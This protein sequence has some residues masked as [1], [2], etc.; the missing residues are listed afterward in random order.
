MRVSVVVAARHARVWE[1]LWE[2]VAQ[3]V[4]A[5]AAATRLTRLLA[6]PV[7]ATGCVDAGLVSVADRGISG[8]PP[9]ALAGLAKLLQITLKMPLVKNHLEETVS[10]HCC[11]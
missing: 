3:L 4:D 2:Q 1:I 7:Q 11:P 8:C 9:K 5:V 6:V 10:L